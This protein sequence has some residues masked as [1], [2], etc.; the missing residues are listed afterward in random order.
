VRAVA[1]RGAG[2]ADLGEHDAPRPADGELLLAP[3][4]VGL[5]ATDKELLEG[6]M[7]YL[8]SGRTRLP[9]VPGHEWV[10][11]VVSCG[12]GVDEPAI[13]QLVVGECSI[14]CGSCP[15]CRSGAYH[16]CPSRRE[17]GILGLNGAL[18]TR[19][20]FP[21]RSAHVVPDGVDVEDAALVE[22]CAVAYRAL[23]RAGCV[24]SC[25]VLV[26]GAGTIGW[27]CIALARSCFDAEVGVVEP[28]T[29]RAA[30]A[31]ALGCRSA[32]SEELWD[33]AVVAT[34]APEAIRDA[35]CRVAPGGRLVLVGLTGRTAVPVDTDGL[36]V[37]DQELVGTVGSPGVW[38]DVL[39]ILARGE[40][41]PSAIVTHRYPLDAWEEGFA[42]MAAAGRGVG[43]VL[44][45]PQS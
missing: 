40:V 25:R 20:V 35:Q 39:A 9:L 32:A 26:V 29:V 45:L 41:R 23:V 11:R 37:G 8:R 22:P 36:V 21:A 10:A 42:V 38:P 31:V 13:G 1:I 6:D 24:Q 19:M 33:R 44:V 16:R 30:R 12:P 18:S 28:D 17:T 4:A 5:C 2:L 3:L 43:K 15:T 7:V 14:G 34:G 27:L